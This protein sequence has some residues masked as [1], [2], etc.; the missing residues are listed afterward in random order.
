MNRFAFVDGK[1]RQSILH[2]ILFCAVFLTWI[3]CAFGSERD[4]IATVREHLGENRSPSSFEIIEQDGRSAVVAFEL[5]L[6]GYFS[7]SGFVVPSTRMNFYA[8]LGTGTAGAWTV[9]DIVGQDGFRHSAMEVLTKSAKDVAALR[10]IPPDEV[11]PLRDRWLLAVSTDDVLIGDFS[12]KREIYDEIRTVLR[13]LP[14]KQA[15]F[16]P[17]HVDL[18]LLLREA[19]VE[20]V[21]RIVLADRP[22]KD[23]G[24]NSADCFT[25]TVAANVWGRAGYLHVDDDV[26]V[27]RMAPRDYIV[28]RPLGGRWYF[29]RQSIF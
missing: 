1:A 29:F 21:D 23:R 15:H 20:Y 13:W 12:R 22:R 9:V 28:I 4:L 17:S 8:Y 25:I 5:L 14:A 6:K 7:D 19:N 24:C 2:S 27:P 10:S 3:S 16:T 11:G 18:G 26:R